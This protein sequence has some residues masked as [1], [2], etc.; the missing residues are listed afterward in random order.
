VGRVAGILGNMGIREVREIRVIL[1]IRAIPEIPVT[2]TITITS[3]RIQL[4]FS[5]IENKLEIERGKRAPSFGEA[6]SPLGF[7]VLF[8]D[9]R[10]F[11]G[12]IAW[13]GLDDRGNEPSGIRVARLEAKFAG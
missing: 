6:G 7:R 11:L 2:A 12:L 9:E 3:H 5:G 10:A 1:E 4:K 8:W 13:V